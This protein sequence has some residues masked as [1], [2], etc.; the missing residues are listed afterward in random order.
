VPVTSECFGDAL[1]QTP[2]QRE[3]SGLAAV[4]A[5]QGADIMSCGSRDRLGEGLLMPCSS[6]LIVSARSKKLN[7]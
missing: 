1:L 4:D 6:L 5:V 3:A 2:Q 7:V